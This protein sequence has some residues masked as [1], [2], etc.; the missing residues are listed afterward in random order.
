MGT[1]RPSKAPRR[2]AGDLELRLR[3]EY[4]LVVG[5]RTLERLHDMM[6][7]FARTKIRVSGRCLNTGTRRGI[8]VTLRELLD[9]AS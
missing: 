8:T 1:H 5:E 9:W 4:G 2:K 7:R 6:T 3:A